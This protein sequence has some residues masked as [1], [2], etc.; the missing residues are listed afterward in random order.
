MSAILLTMQLFSIASKGS[1]F[2]MAL[3]F[4]LTELSEWFG[5]RKDDCFGL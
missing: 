3:A 5:G 1:A 4:S 2:S